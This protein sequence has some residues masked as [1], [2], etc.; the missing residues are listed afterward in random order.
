MVN[1]QFLLFSKL[2]SKTFQQVSGLNL[3]DKSLGNSV[4]IFLMHNCS[5][6]S[7]LSTLEMGN[8]QQCRRVSL[9]PDE[10]EES[11]PLGQQRPKTRGK[12]RG[13]G[14]IRTPPL[15]NHY[16][17]VRGECMFVSIDLI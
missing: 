6:T 16:V 12:R 17:C 8:R 14:K 1:Q 3:Y 2:F 11:N 4:Y 13:S 5:T 9:E 15:K 7:C 10:E